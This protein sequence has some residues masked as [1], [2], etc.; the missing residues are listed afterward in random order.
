MASHSLK[1]IHPSNALVALRVKNTTDYVLPRGPVAVYRESLGVSF[2]CE[3][4]IDTLTPG[5]RCYIPVSLES[6]VAV[7]ATFKCEARTC[8][9]RVRRGAASIHFGVES[10]TLYSV[11]NNTPE[12]ATVHVLHRNPVS[13]RIG[14]L[15]EAG[16]FCARDLRASSP[17]HHQQEPQQ[18][19]QE[20]RQQQS[21]A[22]AVCPHDLTSRTVT[23]HTELMTPIDTAQMLQLL[24]EF[25]NLSDFEDSRWR[26]ERILACDA[27]LRKW[28]MMVGC[29]TSAKKKEAAVEQMHNLRVAMQREIDS[30][31]LSVLLPSSLSERFTVMLHSCLHGVSLSSPQPQPQPQPQQGNRAAPFNAQPEQQPRP[32]LHNN[33]PAAAFFQQLQLQPQSASTCFP[34]FAPSSETTKSMGVDTPVKQ[35][36]APAPFVLAPVLSQPRSGQS[37]V[38]ATVSQ[39][40][41][42]P[43]HAKPAAASLLGR[44][45]AAPAQ[46]PA[47]PTLALATAALRSNQTQPIVFRAPLDEEEDDEEA[48]GEEAKEENEEKKSAETEEIM[49]Q[50]EALPKEEAPKEAN[51]KGEDNPNDEDNPKDEEKPNEEDQKPKEEAPEEHEH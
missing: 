34:G 45:A 35:S 44:S 21:V 51:P 6:R 43:H 25:V 47:A 13:R 2:I 36:P 7:S 9:L 11:A 22:V 48:K 41:K 15:V 20:Q 12:P 18:E 39:K 49:E 17:S 38:P 26:V 29:M 50:K 1:D 33:P 24:R 27:E 3:A 28:E 5:S 8:M 46:A 10:A 37:Q 14:L 31:E 40:K 42:Q 4:F 23:D 30:M 16:V 19:P 32:L